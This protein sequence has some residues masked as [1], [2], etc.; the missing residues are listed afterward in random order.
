MIRSPSLGRGGVRARRKQPQCP[1]EHQRVAHVAGVVQHGAVHG[2]QAQLVAVVAD[3][4]HDPV[5]DAPRV[6]HP[7]GE[8]CLVEILRPETQHIGAGDGPGRDPQDVAHHT[9]HAGVGPAEGLQGRGVVVGLHLDS[10][11]QLVVEG[12]DAGVVDEHRTQPV[13]L[14]FGGRPAQGVQQAVM[15]GHLEAAVGAGVLKGDPRLEGLV[16]AVLRPGL[17]QG[18]E[19]GVGGIAAARGEVGLD[20]SHLGHVQRQHPLPAQ[21][22]QL[23]VVQAGQPHRQRRRRRLPCGRERRRQLA[24]V[25]AL[26]RRVGQEP[27]GEDP[28]VDLVEVAAELVAAGGGRSQRRESQHRGRPLEFPRRSVGYPRQRRHLHN[29]GGGVGWADDDLVG[30]GVDENLGAEPGHV[31]LAQQPFEVVHRPEAATPE[32]GHPELRGSFRNAP[33]LGMAGTAHLDPRRPEPHPRRRASERWRAGRQRRG[34]STRGSSRHPPSGPAPR[35]LRSAR[36]D[37]S[38]RHRRSIVGA[39]AHVVD[40]DRAELSARTSGSG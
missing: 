3:P 37:G 30:D 9:A 26:D 36:P 11:V 19:F 39:R 32:P 12:D 40:A 17:R 24:A 29:P 5:A 6:Q 21:L 25:A 34:P 20:G 27:G 1:A 15:V 38:S 35:P 18:L 16:H 23:P 2:G 22:G 10:E 8:V 13:G 7:G 4:G 14:Q 28:D 33:L 31:G